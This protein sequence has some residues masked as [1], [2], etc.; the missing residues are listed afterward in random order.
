MCSFVYRYI[1]KSDR[2]VSVKKTCSSSADL[3]WYNCLC[4]LPGVLAGEF[5]LRT[6]LCLRKYDLFMADPL[7]CNTLGALQSQSSELYYNMSEG[8]H[9]PL[10]I[11]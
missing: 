1:E 11:Y 2:N 4:C 6:S 5:P 8:P 10:L 7:C 3:S 9:F